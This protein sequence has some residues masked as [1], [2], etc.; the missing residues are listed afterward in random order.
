VSRYVLAIDEGSTGVR[1]LLFD[2]AGRPVG[3]AHEEIVASF[4]RPGWV[5]QDAEAIWEATLRVTRMAL[6]SAAVE[7]GRLAAVGV[8]NQRSTAVVWERANGRP[9]HAALGWQDSRTA[10]R[11]EELAAAGVWA[12]VMTSST[13]IEWIL[14]NV[15]DGLAR[16]ERGDLCFGTIDSWLIWKLSGGRAHVTDHSNASCT[17]L[18]EFIGGTWD[19]S[20][21]ERLRLPEKLLPSIHSSS[22]VYAES[23]ASLLG[24]RVPIAAAA[25]DQQAAL[26]GE[27]GLERGA[28][29]ITYGTSGMADVNLGEEIVMPGRGTYP[30]VLWAFGGK[31]FF[32]L[33]GTVITAGAGVQW[34]RDGLGLID[35]LADSASLAASVS[36]AGGVWFVPALQGLGTPHMEPAARGVLGGLSRGSGRGHV[37]R[38][39]LEGIAFRTREVLEALLNDAG[40]ERP[41]VLRVDGGAAANDFLLQGLADVLGQP[42]ERPAIVQA[43]ATGIAYLAGIAAGLWNGVDEVRSN[44]RSGGV[45]EPRWPAVEREE[46]FGRWQR[47]VEA[48]RLGAV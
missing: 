19:T 5:E 46:R 26:F 47:T 38:A 4:P 16:A 12:S 34:L 15:P 39:V 41:A 44:W 6:G 42:V 45:F 1:A 37:A 35:D 9:V 48:A 20:M 30:L 33:E 8:A 17:G 25:G 43:T 40:V 27:I 3:S 32:C 11:V 13:K 18:Y 2:S 22:E 29:K 21:L 28:A 36:D 31:R 24:A 10:R 23:D 14:A 7:P